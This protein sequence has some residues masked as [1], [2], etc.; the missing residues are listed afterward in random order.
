M[1]RIDLFIGTVY[2][3]AALV[4]ERLASELEGRGHKVTLN[5]AARA[6]HLSPDRFLILVTST[7]GQ[8]DIPDNLAP[9]A[10]DLRHKAPWLAPLR[11][12]L[13]AMGDSAYGDTFCCAGRTLDGLLQELG[14]SPLVARLEIDASE[15]DEPERP[16]LAWLKGWADRLDSL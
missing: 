4:A 7:T 10:D 9:F 16:A 3:Q 8:G 14:A 2:G 6:K 12:A 1:A 11:Y 5:E 15:E 13:V